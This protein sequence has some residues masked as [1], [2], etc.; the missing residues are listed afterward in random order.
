MGLFKKLKK[1]D[2]TE[3]VRSVAPTLGAALGGPMGGVAI[4]FLADN[5]LPG[6]AT[7]DEQAVAEAIAAA[8]PDTLIQLRKLDQDF[9]IKMRELNI[10]LEEIQYKDRDSARQLFRINIWP[11]IILSSLY[12]IGY[13]IIL[14]QFL[15]GG[16]NVP[17]ELKTEF[18]LILGVLTAGMANI[19]QFWF[20]SSSGSKEKT[21]A[22]VQMNGQLR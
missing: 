19:M 10:N 2:W 9:Q 1:A 21:A 17:P 3:V 14:Q 7:N 18:S 6:D 8:S 20:G 5:L 15:T 22:S 4:K 12:V 11:Q 16:V 13:I